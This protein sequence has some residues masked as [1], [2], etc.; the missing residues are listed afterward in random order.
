MDAPSGTSARSGWLTFAG[1]LFVLVGAF[2]VVEGLVA[3][4][5]DEAFV[6]TDDG[7]LFADFTAWGWFFLIFGAIQVLVG[8]GIYAGRTWARVAGVVLAML[9]AVSQIAFLVAF[10]LWALVTIALNVVV[11]YGLLVPYGNDDKRY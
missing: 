3:L 5:K 2:N 8:F 6:V 10:P 7:L 1:T 9:N 4:A 11:V